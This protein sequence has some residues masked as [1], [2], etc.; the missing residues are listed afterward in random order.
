MITSSVHIELNP[1]DAG[2]YDR[3]IV[4][5]VIK[6]IAQ[7]HPLIQNKNVP[8]KVL[9]INEVDKLSKQAQAG[10]RRTMEKYTSVCRIILVGCN[11]SKVSRKKP[12]FRSS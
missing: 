6:E 1:S 11:Q 2:N 12:P 8:F 7:N 5:N 3:Y 9:V 4:Q 10:L